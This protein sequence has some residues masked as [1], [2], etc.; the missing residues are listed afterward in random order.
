M[1]RTQVE[2]MFPPILIPA[3]DESL[4][5]TDSLLTSRRSLARNPLSGSVSESAICDR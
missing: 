3:G 5:F 2:R 4:V 1:K